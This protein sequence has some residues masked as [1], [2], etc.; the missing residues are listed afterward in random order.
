MHR[1]FRQNAI[2]EAEDFP[3]LPIDLAQIIQW[4]NDDNGRMIKY[5]AMLSIDSKPS[6]AVKAS[7][8][9]LSKYGTVLQLFK[10]LSLSLSLQPLYSLPYS[11]CRR[12]K[13]VK[14]SEILH[15]GVFM[16]L[17]FRLKPGAFPDFLTKIPS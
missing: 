3:V 13:S 9:N 16:V 4:L 12:C 10:L 17:P 6:A 15:L 5:T 11:M 1:D 14:N 2:F 7:S 8:F